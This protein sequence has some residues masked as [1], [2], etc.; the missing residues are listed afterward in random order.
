MK[1]IKLRKTLKPE[2]IRRDGSKININPPTKRLSNRINQIK[3]EFRYF[4][5]H[6]EEEGKKNGND[7]KDCF[8]DIRKTNYKFGKY[9]AIRQYLLFL[10]ILALLNNLSLYEMMHYPLANKKKWMNNVMSI[11]SSVI[12]SLIILIWLLSV[13]YKGILLRERLVLLHFSG[14]FSNYGVKRLL[15]TLLILIVHPMFCFTGLKNFSESYFSKEKIFFNF[16]RP[17]FDLLIIINVSGCMFFSMAILLE[18]LRYGNNKS[19][20]IA[21]FFSQ[22]AN[23]VYVLRATM[24]KHPIQ[25]IS[26]MYLFFVVYF[27][28]VIRISENAYFYE[29]GDNSA[30]FLNYPDT[31]WL[32]ITTMTTVGYGQ[33]HVGDTISRILIM[34]TG[35]SG[36]LVTS[37]SV[38]AIGNILEMS[39]DEDK[40]FHMIKRMTLRNK[41]NK[42]SAGLISSLLQ[43]AVFNFK[44]DLDK[45]TYFRE[46]A[47]EHFHNFKSISQEYRR[48]CD[49]GFL[50]IKTKAYDIQFKVD[51]LH[52]YITEECGFEDEEFFS[53]DKSESIIDSID[54]DDDSDH[55]ST[56]NRFTLENTIPQSLIKLTNEYN[57][58]TK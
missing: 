58:D 20:R 27:G 12:Q 41:I 24:K 52:D 4:K 35:F 14:I 25:F 15:L 56:N 21:R 1:E 38:I 23:L 30:T 32:T 8:E 49:T 44:G 6:K 9:I 45:K 5:V 2:M 54:C 31:F 47:I 50:Y 29:S 55:S 46:K 10:L 22:E 48:Y 28:I 11:G 33:I 17:I 7:L 42:D 19:D 3:D 34:L 18:K 36:M 16:Q 53:E 13:F 26:S 37:L 43:T 40:A 39:K 57:R 51:D